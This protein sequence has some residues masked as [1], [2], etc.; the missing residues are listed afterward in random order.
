MPYRTTILDAFLAGSAF[1]F[2]LGLM[3]TLLV[4]AVLHG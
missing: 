3:F 4:R 1:G 2:I